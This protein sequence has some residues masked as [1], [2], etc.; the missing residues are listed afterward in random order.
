MSCLL[1]VFALTPHWDGILR[2]GEQLLMHF[3]FT[4]APGELHEKFVYGIFDFIGD[5]YSVIVIDNC[6]I[7]YYLIIVCIIVL[8]FNM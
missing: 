2:W 6:S 1:F 8:F 7:I 3:V 5:N 4:L